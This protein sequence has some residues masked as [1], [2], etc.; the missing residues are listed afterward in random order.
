M[1]RVLVTGANGQLGSEIKANSFEYT[2]MELSFIDKEDLDLSNLDEL[3]NFF[4]GSNYNYIINCAAYTEVD[5][6]EDQNKLNH[7]LNRD[8]PERLA[9]ICNAKKMVL[10]HV[11]TDY[12]F[13]GEAYIPL[14]EEDPTEPKSSYGKSKLEGEQKIQENTDEFFIFR[15]SWL[16]SPYGA[17][18]IKT[19]LKLANERDQLTIVSDQIGTP[20]YAADLAKA[21]L[22]TIS[23]KSEK[24]GVYHFS[25]EGVAS[26]YDFAHF[27]VSNKN[28]ECKIIPISTSEYPFKAQ[29]PLFSLL[30]KDKLKKE[31]GIHPRHW[32]TALKE[33]LQFF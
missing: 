10:I 7:L 32:S 12:V 31:L 26:W 13:S 16:Y 11:S 18:F 3:E 22:L 21:I 8:V 9:K 23:Q 5:N 6:A 15:T 29:R 1:I 17:N 20:T 24:F 33:A 28:L 25:N 2:D 14:T 27:F 19:I 4:G 30:S